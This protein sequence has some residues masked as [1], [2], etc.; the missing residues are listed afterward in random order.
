MR[1]RCFCILRCFFFNTHRTKTSKAHAHVQFFELA[2]MKCCIWN[3]WKKFFP[4]KS[5][6]KSCQKLLFVFFSSRKSVLF[7]VYAQKHQ[8]GLI[9]KL[10]D[11]VKKQ[12]KII[13]KIHFLIFEIWNLYQNIYYGCSNNRQNELHFYTRHLIQTILLQ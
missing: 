2:K 8:M 3:G 9:K 1:F 5:E 4:E 10:L 7:P 13:M 11:C 12:K 6:T